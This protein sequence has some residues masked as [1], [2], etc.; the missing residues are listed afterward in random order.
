[1]TSRCEFGL[2]NGGFARVAMGTVSGSNPLAVAVQMQTR[3]RQRKRT[4]CSTVSSLKEG[5]ASAN[6]AKAI[7]APLPKSTCGV[8]SS[9]S[10]RSH[11]GK[12]IRGNLGDRMMSRVVTQLSCSMALVALTI[13][14]LSEGSGNASCGVGEARS[15][16]DGSDSITLQKRRGLACMRGC[17]KFMNESILLAKGVGG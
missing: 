10:R 2:G 12:A 16:C 4:Q 14:S 11:V 13:S 8:T 9:V 7:M 1:M 15:I 6:Y 17:P 3:R 5:R